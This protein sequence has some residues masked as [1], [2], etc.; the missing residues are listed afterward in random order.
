[1]VTSGTVVRVVFAAL[2]EVEMVG[3]MIISVV[4][5]SLGAAAVLDEEVVRVPK[6]ETGRVVW[7][8]NDWT[9]VEVVCAVVDASTWLLVEVADTETEVTELDVDIAVVDVMLRDNTL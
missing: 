9:E 4:V 1:M 6:P 2:V 8:A 3:G 5:N 7:L